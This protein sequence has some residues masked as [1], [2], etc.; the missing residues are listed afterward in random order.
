MDENGRML[1]NGIPTNIHSGQ[2]NDTPR[3]T[4]VS[5]HL[6]PLLANNSWRLRMMVSF[7]LT[8]FCLWIPHMRTQRIF[9]HVVNQNHHMISIRNPLQRNPH[10]SNGSWT[11][12]LEDLTNIG[13]K[14]IN[15]TVGTTQRPPS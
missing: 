10:Y 2:R 5:K 9:F 13:N 7:I 14:Y 15:T 8:E 12:H 11:G 4:E 1:L 6:L 3:E